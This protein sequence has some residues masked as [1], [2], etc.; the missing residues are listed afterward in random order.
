MRSKSLQ[1]SFYH[2]GSGLWMGL[3]RER[4]VRAQLILMGLAIVLGLYFSISLIEWAIVFVTGGV[5]LGLEFMNS[6]L[7]YIEDI[8]HPHFHESIRRSKDLAAAAVL[9]ASLTSFIVGLLIF[10]P[11]L[12]KV[13]Q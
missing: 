4:N 3:K 5:V 11:Y 8:L 2:A 10:G 6:A 9:M 12:L 1:E 13:L 7:E